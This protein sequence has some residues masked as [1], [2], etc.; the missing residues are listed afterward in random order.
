MMQSACCV[1]LYPPMH[2]TPV[3][4]VTLR[5]MMHRMFLPLLL[6]PLDW[7]ICFHVLRPFLFAKACSHLSALNEVVMLACGLRVDKVL[8]RCI[9]CDWLVAMLCAAFCSVA[10][11]IVALPSRCSGKRRAGDGVGAS[12]GG[13]TANGGL[14]TF[15]GRSSEASDTRAVIFRLARHVCDGGLSGAIEVHH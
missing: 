15:Q 6:L 10:A 2:S 3:C 7:L 12:P 9:A 8:L 13:W 1:A 4:F 11:E 5:T 14:A